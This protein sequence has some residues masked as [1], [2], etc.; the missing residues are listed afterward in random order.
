MRYFAARATVPQVKSGLAVTV[1][2]PAG[3]S[4]AGGS[5]LSARARTAP[6]AAASSRAA[7]R[8]VKAR[9]ETWGIGARSH[10]ARTNGV[11]LAASALEQVAS[12]SVV[13]PARMRHQAAI[14]QNMESPPPRRRLLGTGAAAGAGAL[15]AGAP[16]AEAKTRSKRTAAGKTKRADV[17]VV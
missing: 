14:H 4:S 6:N 16:A 2:P 10:A 17:V 1:A 12:R 11:G 8:L 3:V 15:I 13:R 7:R 9:W 5:R